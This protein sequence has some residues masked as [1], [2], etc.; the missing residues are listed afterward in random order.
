MSSNVVTN[1]TNNNL[2]SPMS[3]HSSSG[4][5][6]YKEQI[7][8][9]DLLYKIQVLKN[10]LKA[11]RQKK[12][13]AMEET[14]KIS[15]H[16]EDLQSLIEEK[17]KLVVKAYEEKYDLLR[18]LEVEKLITK[19]KQVLIKNNTNIDSEYEKL[20]TEHME[21]IKEKDNLLLNVELYQNVKQEYQHMIN[22][23]IEKIKSLEISLSLKQKENSDLSSKLNKFLEE[24]KS[25]DIEKTKYDSIVNKNLSELDNCY[26]TIAKLEETIKDQAQMIGNMQDN[27]MRHETENAQLAKKLSELKNAVFI[28]II[29]Y[30]K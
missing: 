4:N 13:D 5:L 3:E 30:V 26:L 25:F 6:E 24:F 10:G 2:N 18:Q 19:R 29:K 11:E 14:R 22:L 27:L 20:L 28:I 15:Q 1:Y 16:C 12:E 21:L 8:I 17:E 7:Y 23:Q 9:K